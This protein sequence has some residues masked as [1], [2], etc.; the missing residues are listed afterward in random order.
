MSYPLDLKIYVVHYKP[1]WTLKNEIFEP[2]QG[3]RAASKTHLDM[4]GD[5]TGEN[6]SQKNDRYCE[7]T[8]LYWIWKNT[9]TEWVGF[10]H[11]RRYFLFRETLFSRLHSRARAINGPVGRR[12]DRLSKKFGLYDRHRLRTTVDDSLL[13]EIGASDPERIRRTVAP[14]DV[15][16]TERLQMGRS[17]AEDYKRAH[18]PQDWEILLAAIKKTTPD[19][20][21]FMEK[22]FHSH[23]TF[24][25]CNFFIM[26]RQY[27]EGYMALLFPVLFEV[28]KRITPCSDDYQARGFAYM[29][30]RLMNLYATR[31]KMEGKAKIKEQPF[32]FLEFKP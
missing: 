3:G 10:C 19:Y 29:G 8:A 25:P 24:H 2:I 31:L 32:C 21:P 30:E 5:H 17:L 23:T 4:L 28:E 9:A 26:R 11:Y 1:F 16:L 13:D 6:I 15:V 14:Y 12:L 20:E 22:A 18:R 7:L 27:F